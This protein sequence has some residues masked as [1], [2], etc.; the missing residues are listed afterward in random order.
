MRATRRDFLAASAATSLAF[1]AGAVL[2]ADKNK[3]YRTAFIGTGWWGMVN[4]ARAND[5]VIQVGTHRRVSPHNESA[6]NFFKEGKLGK[7]G[8][9]RA[10]VHYRGGPGKPEPDSEPPEGLDWDFWCGPGPLRPFNKRIHPGVS[11]GLSTNMSLLGMLSLKLGR[12]L[13]WD[14]QEEVVTDD[15]EANKLLRR[16]YRAPWKYPEIT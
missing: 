5:R 14:G 6:M 9:V 3:E 10:F 8:M 2:G 13:R 16:R 7:I 4:A 15:P 11:A 1:S 12:S